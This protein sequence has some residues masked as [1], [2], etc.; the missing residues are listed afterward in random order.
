LVEGDSEY[1]TIITPDY[2]ISP[3]VQ[4]D[5]IAPIRL[6]AEQ[7]Q[8]PISNGS[9]TTGLGS[10]GQVLKSNGYSVYWASDNDSNT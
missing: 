9:T 10:S 6:T 2:V 7:I 4:A 5:V 1:K 8:A 3:V